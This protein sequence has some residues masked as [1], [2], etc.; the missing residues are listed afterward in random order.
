MC[1]GGVG[2]GGRGID[3]SRMKQKVIHDGSAVY[4][5]CHISGTALFFVFCPQRN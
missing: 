3:A 5:R 4:F 1:G 2:G